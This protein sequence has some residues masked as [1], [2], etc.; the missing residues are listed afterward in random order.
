MPARCCSRSAHVPDLPWSA[1]RRSHRLRRL[2]V[3]YIEN[4]WPIAR[5]AVP[6]DGRCACGLMGCPAPHLL[7]KTPVL[8]TTKAEVEAAFA[9][10]RWAIALATRHFD[11]VELPAQFGAPLHHQLR[12]TCPTALAPAT[13]RWQFYVTPGSVPHGL[14]E[15]AGGKVVTGPSGWVA[16]P[17]TTT[18]ASGT[19]CW[20]VPPYLTHWRPYQRRDAIDMVFSTVDWSASDAP[21]GELPKFVAAVLG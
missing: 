7:L 18:E 6:R 15:A 12:T 19:I 2:A 1:E 5:L 20:L 10:A 8:I 21:A 13:R 3:R 16:A 9:E 17:G 14:V 11:V 4:G